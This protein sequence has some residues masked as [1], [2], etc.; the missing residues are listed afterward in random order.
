MNETQDPLVSI[1]CITYNHE[2]YI[3]DSIEGFLMQKTDFSFEIIIHDDA[4]T[5]KTADIVREY[6]MKYPN[7]IKPIYQTENQYS[8]GEQIFPN[9]YMEAKGK[10]FALCEGDDYW[11]DPCKLQKQIDAMEKHPEC[12]ICFHPVYIKNEY[13]IIEQ[14]LNYKYPNNI[15]IISTSEVIII[16]A[17][18]IPTVSTVLRACGIE[19]IIHPPKWTLKL[20][21]EHTNNTVFGSLGGGA[22]FVPDVMAIYRQNT[23]FSF[24][25]KLSN[26]EKYALDWA[27]SRY[28]GLDKLNETTN[29]I[30]NKEFENVKWDHC[31]NYLKSISTPY[32]CKK[33]FFET[34]RASMPIFL[35]LI[36]MLLLHR[37][38]AILWLIIRSPFAKMKRIFAI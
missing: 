15:K 30:Y 37:S 1:C 25:K 6:E 2:K 24:S 26:D 14:K 17:G 22:L 16:G 32:E 38:F 34:N 31:Y 3:R 29:Y 20:K 7:L 13:G 12:N 19:N 27:N 5:D 33:N 8:K 23:E 35:K 28:Y 21:G 36:C 11:I 4:S 9:A 10:Y 18:F